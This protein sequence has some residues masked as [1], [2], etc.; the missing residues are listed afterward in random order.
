MSRIA[1]VGDI[2][3][4]ID[5]M[6][7]S[8]L[9]SEVDAIIQ[10]SD[11]GTFVSEERMDKATKRH[12]GLGDLVDYFHGRKHFPVPVH[13]VKGNHEDFDVIEAIK[14][15][16]VN[17]LHY[18]EN[19]KAYEIAGMRFGAIGGNYSKARFSHDRR[20]IFG[21]RRRHLN[22][23]DIEDL[24][25]CGEIDAI[26]AHDCPTGAGFKRKFDGEECGSE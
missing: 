12:E 7:E 11:F 5:L 24:Q 21:A 8:V 17:N 10:V 15:G 1:V 26:I 20:R 16:R 22:H 9:K 18:M 19:G 25:K 4:K 2:H 13:F 23:Q 14:A 6:L 3:G